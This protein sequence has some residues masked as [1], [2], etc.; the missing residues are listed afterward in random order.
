MDGA[1]S[2][3]FSVDLRSG[4]A[5]RTSC[6]ASRYS[7]ASSSCGSSAA[8]AAG[9]FF[10]LVP[11][12]GTV[13]LLTGQWSSIALVAG[14]GPGFLSMAILAV[15]N[16]R[17]RHTDR[18]AGKRTLVVRW[19]EGEALTNEVREERRTYN[20]RVSLSGLIARGSAVR[21]RCSL[22]LS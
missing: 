19:G 12:V 7:E 18:E 2:R 11:V 10:G 21:I 6:A 15:N 13:Y 3:P 8:A 20:H 1:P 17:D 14:L 16:Y 9:F 22:L 4:P 5:R